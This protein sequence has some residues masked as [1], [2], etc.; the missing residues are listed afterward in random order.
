MSRFI[1]ARIELVFVAD[2]ASAAPTDALLREGQGPASPA[3]DWF[4]PDPAT[5]HP[6]GCAC[7]ARRNAA[8]LALSRLL[9]ARGRGHAAPFRRVVAI[10]HTEAARAALLSA[11]AEDP[12]ASS[13]FRQVHL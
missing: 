1:D 6:A 10:V 3:S 7:C 13:C 8:A 12:I 9:L 2:P 5:T 4:Q 11:L